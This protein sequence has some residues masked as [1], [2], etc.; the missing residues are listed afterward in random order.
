MVLICRL[1]PIIL[2][3]QC[4]FHLHQQWVLYAFQHLFKLVRW[5]RNGTNVCWWFG[6]YY[7][8]TLPTVAFFQF[9]I[10]SHQCSRWKSV[11]P[12]MSIVC[13]FMSLFLLSS[14]YE[15]IQQLYEKTFVDSDS[16]LQTKLQQLL[17]L[18]QVKKCCSVEKTVHFPTTGAS[19][20][21]TT[22]MVVITRCWCSTM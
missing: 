10:G 17:T 2:Q 5:K 11:S 18:S 15:Q 12:T 8:S 3:L 6:G 4:P 16:T 7:C 19:W 21:S 22:V 1:P 20:H 14:L 13:C 9:K